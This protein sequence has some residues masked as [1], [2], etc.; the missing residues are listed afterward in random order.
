M[1]CSG[2]KCLRK[3]GTSASIVLAFHII[4]TSH[5]PASGCRRATRHVECCSPTQRTVLT[6]SRSMLTE[7]EFRVTTY[8]F[9]LQNWNGDGGGTIQMVMPTTQQEATRPPSHPD[10]LKRLMVKAH[11]HSR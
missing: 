5:L 10:R 9:L 8:L 1:R 2:A 6:S 4:H 3:A 7:M 11:G